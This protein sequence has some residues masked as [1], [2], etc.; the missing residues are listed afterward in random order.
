MSHASREEIKPKWQKA[1]IH[2]CSVLGLSLQ[3]HCGA[4]ASRRATDLVKGLEHMS[5]EEQ[6]CDLG[7]F[8]LEKTRLSGLL[9]SIVT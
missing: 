2:L 5:Y 9:F 4:G 7:A 8:S 3:G 1:C 6:L